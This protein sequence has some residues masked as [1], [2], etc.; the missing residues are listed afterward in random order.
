MQWEAYHCA[1]CPEA[2]EH[3]FLA[4]QGVAL[5]TSN[6]YHPYAAADVTFLTSIPFLTRRRFPRGRKI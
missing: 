2:L 6:P 3:L 4:A 5:V 1:P